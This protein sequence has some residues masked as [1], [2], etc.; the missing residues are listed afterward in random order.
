MRLSEFSDFFDNIL[1]DGEFDSL[2]NLTSETEVSCLSFANDENFIKKACKLDNVACLIVPSECS[3]IPELIASGKGIAISDKPKTSFHQ[4][5]NYLVNSHNDN[6]V[7]SVKDTIIG[8]N[9]NIHPSAYIA[10]KGVVI[11]NNVTIEENAIIR[12]NVT[13]GDNS[14]IM[15]GAYIGYGACLA[16]RDADGNLLPLVS[17]GSVKLGHN[18]QIGPYSSV[19]KGLFPYEQAEVGDYS[20]VGFAA[21]LSHNDKVGK[22]TIILDQSQICGNTTLEDNVHIAPQ[23]IV[24]N[25]LK[26]ESKADVA[27]GSV[28]VSNIKKGVRVAGNYAIEN[29][30][31]L[32]WHR[33]KMGT[34]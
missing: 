4:L 14:V 2:C 19:A 3:E 15:V 16:G 8:D 21:D 9:C 31:F 17:A 12:E 32:L 13:I 18:V 1:V 27:I 11:G 20:L 28:V 10:S 22:N 6:Y 30:K 29:S 34:K 33:K 24:S 7:L 26:V 23:A 5:H 25:R